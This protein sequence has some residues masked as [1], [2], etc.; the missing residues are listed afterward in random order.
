MALKV[1][2]KLFSIQLPIS[3]V[4]TDIPK[5]SMILSMSISIFDTNNP[6]DHQFNQENEVNKKNSTKNQWIMLLSIKMMPVGQGKAQYKQSSKIHQ[7]Q[8]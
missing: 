1:W 5:V 3:I 7:K 2:S 6:G 4:D 8:T